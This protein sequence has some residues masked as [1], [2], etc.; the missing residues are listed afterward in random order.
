MLENTTYTIQAV[1][2]TLFLKDGSSKQFVLDQPNGSRPFG[3]EIMELDAYTYR[4]GSNHFRKVATQFAIKLTYSYASHMMYLPDLLRA[5]HMTVHFP[6]VFGD[7][8]AG[9]QSADFVLMNSN[10]QRNWFNN[11]AIGNY[12]TTSRELAN[13]VPQ[14]SLNLEFE[15]VNALTKDQIT[16]LQIIWNN[17]QVLPP[18]ASL[19]LYRDSGSL[20]PGGKG[21][22][23]PTTQS[24]L[25]ISGQVFTGYSLSDLHVDARSS[26]GSGL[27]YAINGIPD[28]DGFFELDTFFLQNGQ[29]QQTFTITI[30]VTDVLGISA[31]DTATVTLKA[32]EPVFD[33]L[34]V[35]DD[36]NTSGDIRFDFF[37]KGSSGQINEIAIVDGSLNIVH[38]IVPSGTPLT[39]PTEAWSTDPEIEL[40]RW[41]HDYFAANPDPE[42]IIRRQEELIPDPNDTANIY[43][44]SLQF[45][46]RKQGTRFS[47]MSL[48]FLVDAGSSLTSG[49]TTTFTGGIAAPDATYTFRNVI[50]LTSEFTGPAIGGNVLEGIQISSAKFQYSTDAGTTWTDVPVGAA[51]YDEGM[52]L[53]DAGVTSA[54]A[55]TSTGGSQWRLSQYFLI[56]VRGEVHYR[57]AAFDA[58]GNEMYSTVLASTSGRDNPVVRMLDDLANSSFTPKHGEQNPIVLDNL[59]VSAYNRPHGTDAKVLLDDLQLTLFS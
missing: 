37:S 19:F 35:V 36:R 45:I 54:R 11:I 53:T 10:V 58:I 9:Y 39:L 24:N 21:G 31:S 23:L 16:S 20:F 22:S 42:V 7:T 3:F 12:S 17:P 50:H 56:P 44:R 27:A 1:E 18:T 34:N 57:A 52:G 30:T 8:G 46:D 51:S 28:S 4:D 26:E 25:D 13:P 47:G 38:S 59:D 41:V 15:S 29:T 55:F 49:G 5:T 6:P 33:T 40:A 32:P 43:Q 14:G 2:I 48:V